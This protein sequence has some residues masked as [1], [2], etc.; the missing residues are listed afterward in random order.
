[1]GGQGEGQSGDLRAHEWQVALDYRYLHA[2]QFF[3]GTQRSTPPPAFF[4]QPLIIT[5]HSANV[6]LTYAA[7]DRFSLRLTVPVSQGSQSRFYADTAR[8]VVHA[9]GIGD[10]GLVG[11]AWLLNSRTHTSANVALGLGVKVPT[12]SNKITDDYFLAD[13]SSVQHSVDQSVELGDGGWGIILQ[14]QAFRRVAPRAFAYFTGSYL[15]SPRNQTEIVRAPVGRDTSVHYSV[16]DVYTGRLGVSYAILPEQGLTVGLGGR[17]DGIPYHDL[18]GKSDGF[19][20]PGYAVFIDPGVAL[21][22]G[23]STFMF[24]APIRVAQRLATYQ[25]AMNSGGTIG[26]GDLAAVLIFVGYA[27]RF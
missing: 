22:R 27:R 7:T 15:V 19:R 3:F 8:H 24:S 26:A 12:G 4:G 13:G 18:I 10:V 6:N 9:G 5:I 1:L 11:T 25:M 14:G 21:A 23:R 2:D 17:I 16:S 20:R